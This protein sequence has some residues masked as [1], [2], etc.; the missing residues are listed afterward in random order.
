[1]K[2]LILGLLLGGAFLLNSCGENKNTDVVDSGTYQGIAEEVEVDEKE[3]YVRTADDKLVELYFT[4]E[5]KL[6]TSDGQTTTFD[7]LK[8]NGKVEITVE[9]QGNKNV[10]VSVKIL[11]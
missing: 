10:P 5:T 7:A 6:M 2:K 1:M 11:K 3:I 8:E 4:E 9:K